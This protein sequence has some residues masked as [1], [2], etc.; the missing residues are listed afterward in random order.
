[1]SSVKT[2][3]WIE[4]LNVY[5]SGKSKVSDGGKSIKLSANES[6]LGP[7][8][9]AIAA[10]KNAATSLHRYPDPAYHDLRAAIAEK[11]NL[12]AGRIICGVGSDEILK[13]ACRAYLK[14]G[15]EAIYMDHSFSMYPIATKS[16]GAIP[17]L[18]NDVDYKA[19]IDNILAAITDRTRII[20][21]ANPN[22]PTGTY[23]PATDIKH[24]W[25]NIPEN[26][27]LI[28]DGAYAEF[29]EEDDYQAG[30][31]LIEKSE[32]VLMTRTFSK[33]YGLAALRLGW[34]YAAKEISQTLDKIRDPFN[35]P[36]S[37]QVAGIAALKD[38]GFELKAIQFNTRW[39]NWLSQQLTGLGLTI[40]PSVTNFI[41]IKFIAGNKSATAANEFLLKEGYILR[42]YN[43]QG[44]DD[45]LRL[46]VGTEDENNALIRLLKEFME[47]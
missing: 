9:L 11:Y 32:N 34:G 15:D 20:F 45:C 3:S 25:Q 36:S 10:Y 6:A 5:V 47:Q 44:L 7:S 38:V 2:H 19:N 13:L 30:I 40:I 41:L 8:P 12:D 39:R 24:L 16:V 43:E 1:M 42:Y 18:V 37:A 21:L 28:L 17:V 31:E 46:T 14:P 27:L 29:V 4:D 22:N 35:V 23:L 33:L 26:V